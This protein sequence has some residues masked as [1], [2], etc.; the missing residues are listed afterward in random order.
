MRY[1]NEQKLFWIKLFYES[2]FTWKDA[3]QR[4]L[5]D[6]RH[7]TDLKVGEFYEKIKNEKGYSIPPVDK[8]CRWLGGGKRGLAN[9]I[10]SN[11][12]REKKKGKHAKFP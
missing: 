9:T 5:R 8:F 4:L 2:Y 1:P 12:T 10:E 7:H 6:V 11:K 3:N